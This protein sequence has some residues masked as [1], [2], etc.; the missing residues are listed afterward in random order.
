MKKRI[1]FMAMICVAS[2]TLLAAGCGGGGGGTTTNNNSNTTT[3]GDTNGTTTPTPTPTSK[4]ITVSGNMTYQSNSSRV[5]GRVAQA[6]GIPNASVI[7]YVAGDSKTSKTV[8]N[9]T[10]DTTDENGDF[11]IT[12]DMG[13][14]STLDIIVEAIAASGNVMVAI[15]NASSNV[16]DLAG[17]EGTTRKAKIFHYSPNEALETTISI[18]DNIMT[19]QNIDVADELIDT[20]S[21][22]SIST[23]VKSFLTE[24]K[25]AMTTCNVS[26][27]TLDDTKK[28]CVSTALETSGATD[29]AVLKTLLKLEMSYKSEIGKLDQSDML[30]NIVKSGDRSKYDSIVEIFDD[31]KISIVDR[32][33]T[34]SEVQELLTCMDDAITEWNSSSYPTMQAKRVAVKNIAV[35][36]YFSRTFT[37]SSVQS[38]LN[39]LSRFSGYYS[40]I[41]SGAVE[42]TSIQATDI[43]YAM[44][45][46]DN[47][48]GMLISVMVNDLGETRA[49]AFEAVEALLQVLA[50]HGAASENTSSFAQVM[51]NWVTEW[52][53]TEFEA[54][55]MTAL[56]PLGMDDSTK[57]KDLMR[58]AHDL[59]EL[60]SG[61]TDAQIEA[62]LNTYLSTETT[63]VAMDVYDKF[64]NQTCSQSDY[65]TF[66]MGSGINLNLSPSSSCV[67]DEDIFVLFETHYGKSLPKLRAF[68][69]GLESWVED[70]S[71]LYYLIGIYTGS[72][73]IE[74]L[75][76]T[77]KSSSAN[78]TEVGQALDAAGIKK[79]L[80]WLAANLEPYM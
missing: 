35:A 59:S 53:K 52:D 18:I 56:A 49:S 77:M 1:L 51:D 28:E 12:V 46:Y 42:G 31:A 16:T 66:A 78:K 55:L 60:G 69:A 57:T 50:D 8:L 15:D 33:E 10:S 62:V 71:N 4:T 23:K 20:S 54:N 67:S 58:I 75:Y 7:A 36:E 39:S 26:S 25:S 48:R 68:V 70:S 32:L 38:I 63:N 11:S 27:S 24:M 41:R 43:G 34:S 29:D 76:N 37:N 17:N 74:T 65:F 9:S 21:Y 61:A 72:T 14:A 79:E 45:A 30:Y 13:N 64:R 6:G 19:K 73:G 2:L 22:N 5:A 44:T 3:Q 80:M 40:S 47:V